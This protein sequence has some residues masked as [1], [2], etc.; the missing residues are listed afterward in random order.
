MDGTLIHSVGEHSNRLH[1]EAFAAAFK[2]VFNIDTSIGKRAVKGGGR[3]VRDSL[4]APAVAAL[5]T[6]HPTQCD[7]W[8]ASWFSG[9][10]AC[11]DVI[12][13]HGSTDPLI[14]VKVLTHA[15]GVDK[16]E[17]CRRSRAYFEVLPSRLPACLFPG[18]HLCIAI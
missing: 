3:V 14:L 5:R 10:S 4:K 18:W 17:V 7:R 11:A 2:K 6:G 1:K 8:L 16:A 12:K 15:H 9:R 13:H